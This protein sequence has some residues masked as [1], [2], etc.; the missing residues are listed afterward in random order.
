MTRIYFD[1]N[2]TTPLRPEVLE[3]MMPYLMEKCGNASSAHGWGQEARAA[4]EEA[5][6]AVA[7][8]LR[9][10]PEEVCF[11]GGG[12]EA[13]N[14]ALKGVALAAGRRGKRIVTS[15]VEHHAVWHTCQHLE[16]QGF[17]VVYVPVDEHGVVD[18]DDVAQAL[19]DETILISVMHANNETGSLQPAAE[20]GA[21]AWERGIPFHVDAVQTFG[22]LPV[23]V[24]ELNA[25]LVSLSAHKINGPKGTGVLYVRQGMEIDPL[26]HGGGH[27]AGR[28]AGTENVAGIVGMGKATELRMAE[29]ETAPGE[30]RRLRDRLEAGI[31]ARLG[32]VKVNGHPQRRLVNTLN[33]V[34]R[35]VEAEGV[36][37][38]LDLKGVAAGSGSACT[39]GETQ[40]SHVLLAMGLEPR[41]AANAV[42]FSLGWENTEEEVDYALEALPDIVGR[43]REVSVF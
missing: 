23:W 1:H 6:T 27:E 7:G 33:V 19:N 43:L 20:I 3:A 12:T 26:M 4:V 22:K 36:V 16:R 29:M 32:D 18:P 24:D 42:R 31:V 25:D 2:A 10:A 14:W 17:E 11:T 13:D 5:R 9:C 8:A 34:F 41:L 15:A 28:R 39:S 30:W 38:G 21:L 35:G 40:P 37:L